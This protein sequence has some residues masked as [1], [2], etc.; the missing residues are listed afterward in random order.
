[1]N[2][3]RVVT[4]GHVFSNL[5]V[6]AISILIIIGLCYLIDNRIV[7]KDNIIV[8]G[9]IIV[10][11]IRVAASIINFF[12]MLIVKADVDFEELEKKKFDKEE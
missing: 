6:A 8:T 9:L 4:W 12:K 2:Q 5:I 3:Q 10:F 11:V 1:M 7:N